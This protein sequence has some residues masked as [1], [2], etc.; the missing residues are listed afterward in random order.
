MSEPLPPLRFLP[1]TEQAIQ[2]DLQQAARAYLQAHGDHRYA[3]A[4]DK[5]KALALLLL[6]CASYGWMLH[7]PQAGVFFAAYF[8]AIALSMLLNVVVNHDASH[9][10]F[11]RS[12]ALN[13]L[14]GRIVTLPLG[15]EPAFWRVRHVQF[16]H[17]YAN[18]E[19]YDLDTEENGFF[20]QT[21]FQRRR[22]F[23]RYQQLYWPVIAGLSLPWIAWVFDWSDRLG[24]T[25]LR[26]VQPLA[27]RAGWAL[28]LLGKLGHVLLVLVLPLWA[29][30]AH[31]VGTG[32]VLLAYGLSQMF[33]S[34]LVV[35][36]LLGTHWAET[37]FFQPPASG[38][39]DHGW[40]RH[41]FVTA[42]DWVPTPR[43]LCAFTGGLNYHLT[44]HLFP[45]WHHRHYPALAALVAQV[46]RTHGLPYRCI[47]YRELL[48]AQRRFLRRM[49]QEDAKE[50]TAEHAA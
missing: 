7:T 30:S 15:I 10:V 47:G 34:L 28:F 48:A 37:E 27:G 1:G 20:R 42:C 14:A 45:G 35:Y 36:L 46:A 9:Q 31:G 11:F 6:A 17:R 12:A 3:G 18:I 19:H 25:P 8:A 22:A 24:R 39:L 16:H 41:N 13:R 29:A 40:Y 4:R 38:T 2:R 32:T 43:W 33:A 23:M 26:Q 50:G 5:C 21:P 49:G 44:H